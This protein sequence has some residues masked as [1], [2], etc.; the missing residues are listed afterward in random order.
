LTPDSAACPMSWRN[1]AA[2]VLV[3][4][5]AGCGTGDDPAPADPPP[6][7][8]VVQPAEPAIPPPTQAPTEASPQKGD[9]I[10]EDNGNV[11]SG[12]IDTGLGGMADFVA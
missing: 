2:L 3:A 10:N 9:E 1:W 6:P 12:G 11:P 4:A 8:P 7:P 5:A